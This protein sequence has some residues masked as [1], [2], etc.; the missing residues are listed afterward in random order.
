MQSNRDDVSLGKLVNQVLGSSKFNQLKWYPKRISCWK[1]AAVLFRNAVE[2][3]E[4]IE[5]YSHSPTSHYPEGYVQMLKESL[6]AAEGALVTAERT[7]QGWEEA[8]VT[9]SEK[10]ERIFRP[11]RTAMD[12]LFMALLDLSQPSEHVESTM[13][14]VQAAG[15][16][17]RA[18]IDVS[19]LW[20]KARTARLSEG[21]LNWYR[22]AHALLADPANSTRAKLE[23]GMSA[24]HRSSFTVLY[25]WWTASY[26][27]AG[28]SL[29]A[30]LEIVRGCDNLEAVSTDDGGLETC[31]WDR[32]VRYLELKRWPVGDIEGPDTPGIPVALI[33]HAAIL[34]LFEAEFRRDSQTEMVAETDW[35]HV[36]HQRRRNAVMGSFC[37][38]L[39]WTLYYPSPSKVQVCSVGGAGAAHHTAAS[40]LAKG[41]VVEPCPWLQHQTEN[42]PKNLPFFLWDTA[43]CKTIESSTLDDYPIYTVVSHTWGRWAKDE[44]PADIDGVPWKVPQNWRF[45]VLELPKI[46]KTIPS[47][48][49]YVWFDLLCIPQDFSTLGAREISRQAQIFQGAR[50]AI[51]W[52]NDVESLQGL[53]YV[54]AWKVLHLLQPQNEGTDTRLESVIEKIWELISGKPSGLLSGYNRDALPATTEDGDVRPLLQGT[55][56]PWFTSLWTLQEVVLRP[57][58]WLCAKDFSFATSDGITPLPLSGVVTILRLFQN[59]EVLREGLEDYINWKGA[60]KS[61]AAFH[62]VIAWAHLSG[63]DGLLNLD[64]VAVL[65]LGDRRQCSGRRAE[66]IMSAI[67]ITRW[68]EEA[69]DESQPD[70]MA[71]FKERLER[72]LVLGKYPAEFVRELKESVPGSEFFNTVVKISRDLNGSWPVTRGSMLPFSVNA[73]NYV[74]ERPK[75]RALGTHHSVSTWSVLPTGQVHIQQACVVASS[76]DETSLHGIRCL[77][78]FCD[79]TKNADDQVVFESLDRIDWQS[80]RRVRLD[81]N[82]SIDDLESWVKKTRHAVDNVGLDLGAWMESQIHETYLVLVSSHMAIDHEVSAS[83]VILQRIIPSS[84]AKTGHFLTTKGQGWID[85]SKIDQVDW[86]VD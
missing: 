15:S 43:T 30:I 29:A 76:S 42:D 39:A 8:K 64:R 78:G 16:L 71:E 2:L 32:V 57:D 22:L 75:L 68:Y 24:W 33:Y 14:V 35:S 60:R 70:H 49:R 86:L 54:M 58:M 48:T 79:M 12:D 31:D 50:Y 51:A 81:P 59:H 41:P 19:G 61:H 37:H 52:L 5:D 20:L 3:L 84:L 72:D 67:G 21:L 6:S 65:N 44:S 25:E 69:L 28:H 26:Q 40:S 66:A 63:L 27:E 45:E 7:L 83:G 36:L 82:S 73:V 77:M 13:S 11:V 62:E 74:L 85:T 56:N 55:L 1:E 18:T 53:G 10:S 80:F 34:D 38:H 23:I 47:K 9:L 4:P 46:L 17:A